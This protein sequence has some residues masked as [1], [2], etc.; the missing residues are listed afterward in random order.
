MNL[1]YDQCAGG[2]AFKCFLVSYVSGTNSFNLVC[3]EIRIVSKAD[4]FYCYLSDFLK[5]F[6]LY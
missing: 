2:Q 5:T 3:L 4:N 6:H 1:V